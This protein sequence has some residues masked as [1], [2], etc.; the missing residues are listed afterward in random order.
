MLFVAIKIVCLP[1]QMLSLQ[2]VVKPRW[3]KALQ[4]AKFRYPENECM[5]KTPICA[6]PSTLVV[7]RRNVAALTLDSPSCKL[8]AGK[9]N[10]SC[11]RL[12]CAPAV[13]TNDTV[14]SKANVNADNGVTISRCIESPGAKVSYLVPPSALSLLLEA[15][16]FVQ[17]SFINYCYILEAI[18]F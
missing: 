6:L 5:T 4:P 1:V 14:A 3:A 10:F 18:D 7:G 11:G 17:Y 16:D 8:K 9:N 13:E 15:S 12:E 2:R